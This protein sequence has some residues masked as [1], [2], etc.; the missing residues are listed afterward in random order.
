MRVE[1]RFHPIPAESELVATV[2]IA[3]YENASADQ[4][5]NEPGYPQEPRWLALIAML[6]SGLVYAALPRNLSV[7]S[8]WLLL[9]VM[10]AVSVSALL[11]HRFG[12]HT[13]DKMI[14]YAARGILPWH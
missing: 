3:D 9:A 6:A 12:N 14:G 7:G 5:H 10:V 8:D 4:L 2:V 1:C 11:S 13:T